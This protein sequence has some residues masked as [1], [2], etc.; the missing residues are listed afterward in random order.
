MKSEEFEKTDAVEK[1]T[2][3]IIL[4]AFCIS[5]FPSKSTGHSLRYILSIKVSNSYLSVRG[6]K[7]GFAAR[8]YINE[9]SHLKYQVYEFTLMVGAKLHKITF[10]TYQRNKF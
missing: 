6:L 7:W 4:N 3:L 5:Q 10:F 1:N 2:F 9:I 8:L